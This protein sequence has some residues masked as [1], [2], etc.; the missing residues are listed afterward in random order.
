MPWPNPLANSGIFFAP[1]RTKAATQITIISVPP[2]MAPKTPIRSVPPMLI[3]AKVVLIKYASSASYTID[4]PPGADSKGPNQR[5]FWRY[6]NKI[7]PAVFLP[8]SFIVAGIDGLGSAVGDSLDPLRVH[9]QV[10]QV[11][12]HGQRAPISQ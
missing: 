9:P 11:F 1:K 4:T 10:G 5:L 3:N 12:A 7:T 8:G 2:K 6:Q